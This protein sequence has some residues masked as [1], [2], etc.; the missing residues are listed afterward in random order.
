MLRTLC[1]SFL[2]KTYSLLLWVFVCLW[3]SFFSSMNKISDSHF[4]RTQRKYLYLSWWISRKKKY[5]LYRLYLIFTKLSEIKK[6]KNTFIMPRNRL[7]G[8]SHLKILYMYIN[9]MLELIQIQVSQK[10]IFTLKIIR[11][12]R[13]TFYVDIECYEAF[14]F[15]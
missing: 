8:F 6:E 12:A 11:L 4:I 1:L 5:H 14:N 9:S 3:S 10:K 7:I 2:L 15:I 13:K